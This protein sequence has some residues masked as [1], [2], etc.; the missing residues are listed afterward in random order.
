MDSVERQMRWSLK[1]K[2][3]LLTVL[4]YNEFVRLG[5]NINILVMVLNQKEILSS[6]YRPELQTSIHPSK[7]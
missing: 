1:G 6:F 3:F 5:N 2:D 7:N 4:N